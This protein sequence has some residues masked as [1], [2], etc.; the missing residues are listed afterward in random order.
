MG[1]LNFTATVSLDGY[2]ADADGDF[3]WSAPNNAVFD[4]HVDRMAQVSTEVL[5]RTTY[6][7]MQ[8]WETDPAD[9]VWSPAEHEFARR[10]RGIDKVVASST[11]T[12]AE[13]GP[14]RARIVADLTL[15]ELQRIVDD[16]AGVVEIFGPTVAA[17]AIRAGLV[18][19]FQFFVVPKVVG[20]GLRALPDDVRMDLKLAE[21]RIFDN[22][23]AYLR[24]VS[25]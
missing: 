6:G 2:A 23:T 13:I 1:I 15:A 9:E 25:S 22:G 10:W 4:F 3:Q 19:Q 11:L 8:Y 17:S 24:Y 12:A 7:L 18:E 16:A 20:G 21:H 14:D 5:G